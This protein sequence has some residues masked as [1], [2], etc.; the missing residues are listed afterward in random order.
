[1]KNLEK[2]NHY[3]ILTDKELEALVDVIWHAQSECYEDDCG[4]ASYI[5][6]RDSYDS[7]IRK[8]EKTRGKS[9]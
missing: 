7:L 4:A 5:P 9:I 6:D 2:Q 3:L 8:I 1:M